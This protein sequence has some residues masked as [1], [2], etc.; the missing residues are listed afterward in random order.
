MSRKKGQK[1]A[2]KRLTP[3]AVSAKDY[4]ELVERCD[5]LKEANA[6]LEKKAGE[7]EFLLSETN[8]ELAEYSSFLAEAAHDLRSPIISMHGLAKYL[9]KKYADP[10]SKKARTVFMIMQIAESLENLIKRV[11]VFALAGDSPVEISKFDLKDLGEYLRILF[12]YNLKSRGVKIILPQSSMRVRGDK[13]QI[14]QAIQN[15][16]GNALD[17]GGEEELTQ[18][19]IECT[20]DKEFLTFCVSNDG[21]RL[22]PDT[23]KKIFE[24][25]VTSRGKG[26]GLGLAIVKKI[27]TRHGGKVWAISGEENGAKFFLQIPKFFPKNS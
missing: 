17:H 1:M 13:T 16:V 8:K 11:S 21:K 12:S 19:V 27:A 26:S 23:A 15:L 7:L 5:T 10:A 18:I 24:R 6:E 22:S 25:Y 20:E 9:Y 2:K 4:Q 14:F 3:K